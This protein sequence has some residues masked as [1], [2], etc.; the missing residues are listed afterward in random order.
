MQEVQYSKAQ[1]LRISHNWWNTQT[2][3]W[4]T[5]HTHKIPGRSNERKYIA[6]YPKCGSLKTKIILIKPRKG[7]LSTCF[8]LAADSSTTDFSEDHEKIVS[9]C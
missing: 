4:K 2:L 7:S 3:N 5:T 8:Q 1:R 9:K 6:L